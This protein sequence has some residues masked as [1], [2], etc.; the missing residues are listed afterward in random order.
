MAGT[1]DAPQ[2][3]FQSFRSATNLVILVWL[4]NLTLIV[5]GS[6][7]SEAS[8][9]SN[10]RYV[11]WCRLA[12]S[13]LFILLDFAFV[14]FGVWITTRYRH[15]YYGLCVAFYCMLLGNLAGMIDTWVSCRFFFDRV[16]R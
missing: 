9:S 8:I 15:K 4:A 2:F 1:M 5:W 6:R 10:P 11:E 7:Y 14:G 12:H 3:N 16:L 13:P